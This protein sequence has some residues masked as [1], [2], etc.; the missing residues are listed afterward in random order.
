[1]GV[2]STQS[3]THLL[4]NRRPLHGDG[5]RLEDPRRGSRALPMLDLN[6][7]KVVDDRLGH[8]VGDWL[9]VQVGERLRDHLR[10]ADIAGSQA[11]GDGFRRC[12]DDAT[13]S[14]R[15]PAV[16][17]NVTSASGG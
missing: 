15:G 16:R 10:K 3:C 4:A 12:R 14:H 1:V 9:L 13:G 5:Q 2:R 6:T 8:H 7:F 17:S 11:A